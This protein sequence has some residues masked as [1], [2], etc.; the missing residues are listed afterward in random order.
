MNSIMQS[1]KECYLCRKMIGDGLE[2]PDR[3]LE[4]HHV[5]FGTSDRRKS[6]EFG[7]KVYLCHFHHTGGVYASVH[8]NKKIADDLCV[9]AQK[10]FER[11]HSRREWMQNFKK[12]YL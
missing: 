5:V 4:E 12:N 2:L 1:R 9:E 3:Y 11:T 8:R 7:L 6:E 10:A